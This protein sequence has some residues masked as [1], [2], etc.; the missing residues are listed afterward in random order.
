MMNCF[1]A[2]PSTDNLEAKPLEGVRGTVPI[3]FASVT[4]SDGYHAMIL[5]KWG[6]NAAAMTFSRPNKA[7]YLS[8]AIGFTNP[9]SRLEDGFTRLSKRISH[10]GFK[11]KDKIIS[12]SSGFGGHDLLLDQLIDQ[13]LIY[14]RVFQIND[15]L[16][17]L[18]YW[19]LFFE[20]FKDAASIGEKI[21]HSLKS[22]PFLNDLGDMRE[23]NADDKH[24]DQVISS[25]VRLLDRRDKETEEHTERVA[26]LAVKLAA[27]IG[28]GPEDQWNIYRGALL[29]DVGKIFIPNEILFKPGSLSKDEW[30]IMKTHP[31]IVNEL[32]SQFSIPKDVLEIPHCHHEKWDG[33]GYPNN[34][35]GEE[36]PMSARIFAIVDVWDALLSD[37]PYRSRFSS[38]EATEY[39]REQAGSHFDPMIAHHFLEI[40]PIGNG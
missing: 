17:S 13:G 3:P 6:V 14:F 12:L 28:V 26:W 32:L 35:T 31:V 27:K 34:L 37:R 23:L 20:D 22:S 7:F 15:I 40:A 39:I 29:H 33:T 38:G 1:P 2:K 9:F 8:S 30:T 10:N 19:F 21:A 24:V 4:F 5:E 11:S 16:T 25:W 18:G 36:I